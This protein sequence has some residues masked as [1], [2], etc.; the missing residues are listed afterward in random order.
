MVLEA[1]RC[2]AFKCL[3]SFFFLPL[4]N[5]YVPVLQL[6]L[7]RNKC[8]VIH[9]LNTV[10]KIVFENWTLKNSEWVSNWRSMESSAPRQS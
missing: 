10:K 8:A 4:L 9:A 6:S 2:Y 3:V 5:F 1:Q 7:L